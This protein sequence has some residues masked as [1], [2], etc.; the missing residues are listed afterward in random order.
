[1]AVT[2]YLQKTSGT[3]RYSYSKLKDVLYLV[4]SE[5]LKDVQI[6]NGEAYISGLTELPLRINGFNIQLTEETSLDERYKF[7]KTLTLSM[8]GYVNYKIFGGRYYAIVEAE[9]GTFFMVNVDFPARITHTFNLSQ[10]TNQTDFTF[11]SL[12]NFPTL[13]LNAE[14]EAVSPVCLGLNVYGIDKLELIEQEK[15]RLDT[16]NRTVVST[17]DFKKVE[18][19]GNSCTFQEVYDGNKVTDTITFDI[20]FDNYKPSWQ[21]NLLE[22]LDNKY[23]AIITPRGNDNKYY[24]GFNFGLE[25]SYTI[26]TAS[27]AG[28]SDVI[29]VTLKETSSYG[30]TAAMDWDE[31]QSTETR[32][33]WVKRVGD[34]VCFECIGLGRARYLVKQE[35][36]Y[37]GNPTGN[38]QVMEGYESQYPVFHIVGTF[39]TEEIFETSE[40]SEDESCH[41]ESTLPT[42]IYFNAVTC[43]TYTLQASCDWEFTDIP[44][45]IVVEP[46]T[47]AANASYTVS[48][49]NTTEPTSTALENNMFLKCCKTNRK[50]NFK[51]QIDSGCI[52]PQRQYINCLAQ[53]VQFVFDGECRIEITS[54][55]PRLTYTI[56]NN[57]LTVR[58]PRNFGTSAIT[59]TIIAANCDCSSEST[60]A[61]IIQDKT[62]ER[63][64][65]QEGFICEDGN[66]YHLERKYTGTTEG[67]ENIRTNETRKGTLIQ[68]GDTRCASGQT[69]WEWDGESYY[70]VNGNKFKAVFEWVSYDGINWVKTG[71]TRLGDLVEENS[72]W[73]NLPVTY[74]WELTSKYECSGTT[75]YYLY[76]KYET[77][78]EQAAIPAYPNEWSVDGNGTM[79]LVIKQTND[80]NCG[81]VPPVEA[82]Y[83]WV[84]I[85]ITEDY[86]CGDCTPT[87]RWFSPS[88]SYYLCVG[89]SKY[90][91]MFYQV[92]YDEGN[93]WENVV[94]EQTKQG[95]LISNDSPDCGYIPGAYKY[96]AT[97]SNGDTYEE[98]TTVG[99]PSI[100]SYCDFTGPYSVYCTNY[101][102]PP[103]PSSA[104]TSLVLGGS[105]QEFDGVYDGFENLKSITFNNGLRKIRNVGGSAIET[106]SIPSTVTDI[107]AAFAR[108]NQ[109]TSV[110]LPSGCTDNY[111]AFQYCS[112]LT[113]VVVENGTTAVDYT[114]NGCDNLE[115]ITVPDSLV[116]VE[117]N[118]FGGTITK[119]IIDEA[120]GLIYLGKVAYLWK[121]SM[122]SG[123]T[124]TIRSGIKGIAGWAFSEQL[125][126]GNVVLP[127]SLIYIGNHSFHSCESLTSVTIPSSVT[128]IAE[129]AF[130][131]C[132]S[133]ASVTVNATTPPI[134][135]N[136]AFLSTN[137]NLIIYVPSSSVDA[138]KAA[139]G[140]KKY[141]DRI[142]AKP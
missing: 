88:A 112:G 130:Y 28:Q 21:Y 67:E 7:Q 24:P 41:I 39:T 98:P 127:S 27:Q 134:L 40:C 99:E 13:K 81:Y 10:N 136:N 115:H 46:M 60:T 121:G 117:G 133:L 53:E 110:F 84:D 138:Y 103:Q 49:C 124:V 106:V 79:Q 65:Q 2:D 61:Y 37:F 16:V 69:K 141:T 42:T 122:N 137:S 114:F 30:T 74:S 36:D 51:T 32:W 66:S 12:S 108:C 72:E 87:Y 3:C 83:R 142:Q 78:G 50:I 109:L 59:W 35:V 14:F 129:W 96:L 75:S 43:N 48:I 34:T 62:Y 45:N 9:D 44:N 76:Q 15:A 118:A 23:S 17:E 11:A 94:P 123:E 71:N 102:T 104:I 126:L 56:G 86:I 26:Q 1:M 33:R 25:P 70:C 113:S 58:V 82:I 140:W 68:S 101:P 29:T 64:I 85:P 47:G 19:L 54:I 97:Y 131:K 31:D 119:W 128:E 107:V 91:K 22:F 95:D 111:G 8:H 73:C 55:D 120:D 135:G 77:R 89:T 20:A 63:W 132:Y 6:D 105:I 90:Y 4:S 18:F 100:I 80:P 116:K 139:D 92:S 5:H 52:R 57:T 38:Y 93:T 125:N